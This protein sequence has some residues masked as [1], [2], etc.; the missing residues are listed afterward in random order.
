MPK[1]GQRTTTA[2][3]THELSS[4]EDIS[5][6]IPGQPKQIA[7]RSAPRR[8]LKY[9]KRIFDLNLSDRIEGV[10]DENIP[11]V[12]QTVIEGTGIAAETL[13][14]VDEI[15]VRCDE[16]CSTFQLSV[17][18]TVFYDFDPGL[19]VV[20]VLS[21]SH[22]AVHTWPEKGYLNLDIVTCTRRGVDPVRLADLFAEIFEPSSLRCHRITF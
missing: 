9:G 1:R 22:M 14:S 11:M 7:R 20:F 2:T 19:S 12:Q 17:L 10:W 6:S 18:E 21:E 3:H 16:I 8:S 13:R 15:R 5:A 4:K